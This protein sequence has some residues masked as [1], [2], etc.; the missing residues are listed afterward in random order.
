MLGNT[1]LSLEIGDL[2]ILTA[3][4]RA[5]FQYDAMRHA[6]RTWRLAFRN[7]RPRVG[8]GAQLAYQLVCVTR[9]ALFALVLLSVAS[10]LSFYL[11]PFFMSRV[12]VYLESDPDRLRTGWGWVWVVCLFSYNFALFTLTAQLWS[13]S[14]TMLRSRIRTQLNTILFAKTLVRKDIASAAATSPSPSAVGETAPNI[15]SSEFSSKAQ[16]MTLMTTDVDRVGKFSQQLFT[17]VDAPIELAIGTFF[18]YNL[19]GVSAFFGLG[20]AVLCL[21]LNHY[22]GKIVAGAQENLMKA[23]DERV[24]LMNEAS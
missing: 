20:V 22:A 17:I 24:A 2:P 13:F 14:T 6:V 8:S 4:M 11:P 10:G 3:D 19:L 23:R 21:P 1:A 15:P 7:W 5:T 12:L 9:G 18:L 16:I